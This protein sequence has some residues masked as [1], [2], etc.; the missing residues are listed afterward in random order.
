MTTPRDD[1]PRPDTWL[2][3]HVSYGETD[4][5]GVVYYGEYLHWFEKARGL[6]IRD[7]GMSYSE[8]EQRGVLLPVRRAEVRYVRPARYDEEVAVRCG[9]SAWGRA[10]MTFAYQVWGPPERSV[11]LATGETEHAAV[12]PNWKPLRIPDWLRSL[13]S[14]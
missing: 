1:F 13:F 8:V 2:T 10:S 5:A 4:C 6:L 12:G 11:L 3:M 9:I 7:H 14:A